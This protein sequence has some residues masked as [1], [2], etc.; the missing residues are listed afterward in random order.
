MLYV[1]ECPPDSAGEVLSAIAESVVSPKITPWEM[2]DASVS[3][4]GQA[5]HLVATSTPFFVFLE[6]KKYIY[7][8]DYGFQTREEL[9]TWTCILTC[10]ITVCLGGVVNF[11]GNACEGVRLGKQEDAAS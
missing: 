10:N 9:C 5:K 7:D 2:T 11:D 1:S 8:L 6:T 3:R 4:A